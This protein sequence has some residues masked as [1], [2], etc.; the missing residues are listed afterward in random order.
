MDSLVYLR[1][2][3]IILVFAVIIAALFHKLKLP[4]VAGFIL[5][6]MIV[7]PRSLAIINDVHQ[8]NALA[9]I[10]IAL[11][12]F[13]I[14]L[15][16][17]LSKLRRLW[18]SIILGGVLQ[19][20][21]SVVA[22]V[23]ILRWLDFSGSAALF[24]GFLAALSSTAIVLRG[25]QQR[26]EIDAPHGRLT[27]G[28]LVFQDLSVVPMM[29][30]IP[31]LIGAPMPIGALATAIAQSAAIIAAVF[32]AA[33][34]IV[35][36]ILYF[37]AQTRQR[38]LFILS[39]MVICIG[40]A[41][42]VARSGASL[43][44]GA[45]LAGIVVAG[46]E[47]R[48]QA[49]ADLESFRDVFAGL[50]FVS[51]GM[52]LSPALIAE[53]ISLIIIILAALLFGKSVVV[54]IVARILRM[55]L[56]VCLMTALILA[57]IGEF[58]FVLIFTAQGTGLIDS[59]FENAL[60]SAAIL[61]MFVA[62]FAISFGPQLANGLGKIKWLSR[63]SQSP[64]DESIARTIAKIRDHVIIGGYGLAGRSLAG[65]L[66]INGIPFVIIDLNVE[67]VRK[68]VRE[69]YNAIFGD[70]ANHD[71]LEKAGVQHARDLALLLNDPTATEQAARV[72]RKLAPRL[73]IIA[74]THYLLDVKPILAAGADAVIP[75]EREAA[76]E[77]VSHTLK[78][79]GV[80][81]DRID[82]YCA[83]I[84]SQ[85]EEKNH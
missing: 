21:L 70:V 3:A 42:L 85:V 53:N 59:A 57:Q 66:K 32:A 46:S 58:S 62:P 43:A 61:S 40:V 36:R 26:G 7:G 71:V 73:Y 45:F 52:F 75:A 14:G 13:G 8:V 37:V 81:T 64:I 29:L 63:F 15:E 22:T 67:N 23:V 82:E 77:V 5:A 35:P 74:R 4:S 83:K 47:F 16:L 60:I 25:L 20:G 76:N 49:L 11:L 48:H 84:R 38:Q 80:E 12:L 68:A 54:F 51:I 39:I 34:Y 2:L 56:R 72:A 55:P 24:I 69:G 18:K 30:I 10:G 9:E 33:I 31:F 65:A 17:S 6:G 28:I 19:V 1:D 27:L 41:Y 78:R 79:R 44:I 50:F